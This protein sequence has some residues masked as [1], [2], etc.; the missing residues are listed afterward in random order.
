MPTWTK[1]QLIEYENRRQVPSAKPEQTVCHD[2][3]GKETRETQGTTRIAIRISSFRQRLVD[4]DNLCPKYII[5]GL[6]Y[7][8]L[9]PNDREEDISLTVEQRRVL[10]RSDERT[11]IEL[12]Q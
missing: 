1:E 5:D 9:I 11:E 12:G 7:A 8:G 6:R 2:S 3:L 10:L 4:P